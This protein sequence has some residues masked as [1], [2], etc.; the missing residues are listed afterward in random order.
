MDFANASTSD[1]VL[2]RGKR[3]RI[4]NSAGN[5]EVF[6]SSIQSTL[7]GN[8][9]SVGFM[10]AL[11]PSNEAIGE[12][13]TTSN[14]A[15]ESTFTPIWPLCCCQGGLFYSFNAEDVRRRLLRYS[16]PSRRLLYPFF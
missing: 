12:S 10:I 2:G 16:S 8:S 3:S 4:S 13:S 15:L 11:W 5:G 6:W 9:E 14:A 7:I 1:P